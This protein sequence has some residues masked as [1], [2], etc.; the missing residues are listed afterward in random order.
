MSGGPG[1]PERMQVQCDCAAPRGR[2]GPETREDH[3][4]VTVT[5]W[6]L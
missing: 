6:M 4:L 5:L 3:N 2:P 1:E